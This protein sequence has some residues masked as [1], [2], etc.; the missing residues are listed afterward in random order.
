MDKL[1]LKFWH[2]IAGLALNRLFK[3]ST[4]NLGNPNFQP[5]FSDIFNWL[6]GIFFLLLLY[7]IARNIYRSI[8][9]E[10]INTDEYGSE[11]QYTGPPK[12]SKIEQINRE[13]DEIEA[14]LNAVSEAENSDGKITP[15]WSSKPP[16]R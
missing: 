5:L 3:I 2:P 10:P 8:I 14:T 13:L 16:E 1:E 7:I 12:Q 9:E 11:D 6:D 15:I 4:D